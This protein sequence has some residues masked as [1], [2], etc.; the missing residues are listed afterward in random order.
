MS[1]IDTLDLNV[2]H[3]ICNHLEKP[4]V[5][6]LNKLSISIRN[7]VLLEYKHRL[8]VQVGQFLKKFEQFKHFSLVKTF[9]QDV[10]EFVNFKS[11][12]SIEK[13]LKQ[14]KLFKILNNFGLQ[15]SR[16][17]ILLTNTKIHHCFQMIRECLLKGI[18][19]PSEMIKRMKPNLFSLLIHN[20]PKMVLGI[21][22]QSGKK[23]QNF[24]IDHYMWPQ[25]KKNVD[26]FL[27]FLD[28]RGYI[29][30][31]SYWYDNVLRKLI[32]LPFDQVKRSFES[33]QDNEL[34]ALHCPDYVFTLCIGNNRFTQ[35]PT[36]FF[37]SD[38]KKI[39][40]NASDDIRLFLC[41]FD[42]AIIDSRINL[43]PGDWTKY[44]FFMNLN[45]FSFWFSI[46]NKHMNYLLKLYSETKFDIWKIFNGELFEKSYMKEW[47][48]LFKLINQ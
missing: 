20:E 31:N 35:N 10:F 28:N 21:H 38:C 12:D 11:L 17:V 16:V 39:F 3:Q 19:R 40:R 41:Y 32:Q 48:G 47:F 24:V 4:D 46:S 8:K 7:L 36:I 23:M 33:F 2:F 14:I 37:E 42:P 25:D 27:P 1:N 26:D 9:I 22:Y 34:S 15:I 43:I 30:L 44:D 13:I 18:T 5:R 45:V 6:V 29:C